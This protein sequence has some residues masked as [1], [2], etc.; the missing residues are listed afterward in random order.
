MCG[1]NQGR[2]LCMGRS[3]RAADQPI[4][5]SFF[6]AMICNISTLGT[7]L[8]GA[9]CITSPVHWYLHLWYSPSSCHSAPAALSLINPLVCLCC[10]NQMTLVVPDCFRCWDNWPWDN[11]HSPTLQHK[12][13]SPCACLRNELPGI[14][15]VLKPTTS[16]AAHP[17]KWITSLQLRGRDVELMVRGQGAIS[18]CCRWHRSACDHTSRPWP[19]TLRLCKA[20]RSCEI[21]GWKALQGVLGLKVPRWVLTGF[22]EPHCVYQRALAKGVATR[23]GSRG[24]GEERQGR[25]EPHLKEQRRRPKAAFLGRKA[26][27]RAS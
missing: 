3:T 6:W 26:A 2:L 10:I 19:C 4:L 13:P 12:E 16:T 8:K 11:G 24:K 5:I 23:A 17:K 9:R 20:L 22:A 21:R 1:K 27:P 25:A 7:A 15:H 18:G 14:S